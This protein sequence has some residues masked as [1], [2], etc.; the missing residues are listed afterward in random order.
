MNELNELIGRMC[1]VARG[2]EQYVAEHKTE[3]Q[4][5]IRDAYG[6]SKETKVDISARNG[7]VRAWAWVGD[8]WDLHLL[9]KNGMWVRYSKHEE[10]MYIN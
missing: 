2:I 9:Y 1:D 4:D 3:L 8:Y 10:N 7:I 5:S 6:L